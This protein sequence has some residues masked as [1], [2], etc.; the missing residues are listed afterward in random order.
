VVGSSGKGC[1]FEGILDGMGFPIPLALLNSRKRLSK[2]QIPSV[3]DPGTEEKGGVCAGEW[4]SV[5]EDV[6]RCATEGRISKADGRRQSLSSNLLTAHTNYR[7]KLT[8]LSILPADARSSTV[9]K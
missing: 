8:A 7:R 1:V 3:G 6:K 2:C 5:V 4:A 9:L